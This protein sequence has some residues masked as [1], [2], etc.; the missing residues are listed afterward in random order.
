MNFQSGVPV[1]VSGISQQSQPAMPTPGTVPAPVPVPQ[2]IPSQFGSGSS[3]SSG[4]GQ[5]GSGTVSGQGAQSGQQGSQFVLS[6]S[7]AIRGEIHRFES[8]HPNIYSIY[9]LVERIDDLALQNQIREHVIS[10]EDSFVNSQEWTLSRS[11][12]EL[13][14]GIVGNLSSGKSALVHRYLTGTYVQEESPEGGRF[15]KEIVVDGQSYLLL[16]RDEGGPPELQFA[17]WVDAV[18]FVFSLEDE[19][20]FQ[21]VYNYFLRL[22]SY[23]N[24]NEV[25]M[26]LVGTQDAISAAN[27]RVIDDS[28]ARKLSN[29][30]KRSTYYETCSTYGL[31]VERVFQDVA[32]KVVALRKKQQL[33]IGPCKSLPNSPSHSSVPNASMPSVHLNQAA[34]GGGAFSDYSSSVPSTPS[35]SQREMRIETIAA[36]NT[37]TPIRKQSKRRSN[38]FTSRKASEQSKSTDSKT[39][40]I[41]SGRAIPIKQGILLKRSGKSLNK[42]WKKKYVTLCDNGLL[43]YH[44]SL[45]DYMQNVH[46]KEIDLLRTT[47]KVP[48]KRPPRAVAT[49]APTA[50]PKTNGLT[51]DRSAM[52][53]GVG[54][55]GAPHSN[56]SSS[57]QSGGGVGGGLA[58]FGSKDGMHQRS[59]SVSSADQWNEAVV[60]AANGIGDTMTGGSG[61]GSATSPKLEP[62]PSP[63]ANRKKHKRKKSTGITKPD[64]LSA[65]NEEQEESFEFVIVSLTGQMWHFEASTHEERELW[66]Q[67]IE[68]QIFASL[69][70]CES[71]KNKSRL[72]SQSDAV[73]IQ[74]I[75]NVRGNSF[76]VDCDAPNP[77][78]A[79]LNL[80]ALICIECSGIHRNL[81]THLSRVRSLDLDDWPVE[82]SMVMTAVGNA[83]ANS[84]WEGCLEGYSKPGTD[85]SREEKERWIRAKYEQKLFL[86]GLPQ[87][88]VPL[89]QQLLRA[90]VEDDLSLVVLLLAHGTKEEVNE[91]YGDGDGRT[92]LHLSCAMANVV[93][94]QLLIWYGVDVKSRDARSQTP[95]SYARRA[96]SQECADILLQHGC[97]NDAG[98]SLAAMATPNMTR[99]NPNVNNNNGQCELNRSVSIM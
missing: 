85:C 1:S 53:L 5:F 77:D 72:G 14:V 94:T 60:N 48:G 79:S 19:I 28:R 26:V 8:V 33:S 88:D 27:P 54:N 90:V 67:A 16:I 52:Q 69:Q 18:V 49:V 89:G 96:A 81:G 80:G 30:L 50:S 74:S 83:M 59:F 38:I 2:S 65:G 92:A 75:R 56:S 70:S 73:A 76:C 36:S 62:P 57:L 44:P 21:T 47:V 95:L 86:Q 93:I 4:A 37:P 25:P 58:G 42:E 66:V 71:M 20:S 23:R 41:G 22:S 31:N 87:S 82:L 32:Q 98:G 63:H 61:L 64:G 97:P 46:G 7:A 35:I 6:N 11:V 55:A 40:S 84:V 24:T 45:H 17:A 91:T 15:K 10:I 78:W 51:K 68:S 99:R 43:T 29:D 39:D 9:D 13:K 12:P 3:A 34:N